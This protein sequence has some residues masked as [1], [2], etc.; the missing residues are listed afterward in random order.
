MTDKTLGLDN[1][2]AMKTPEDSRRLYDQWA[3]TYDSGFAAT[4]EYYLPYLTAE[5]FHAA[6][7]RGPVLDVGAG[8]GLSGT[9]LAELG[10]G[11]LDGLDISTKML[12]VAQKKRLYSRLFLGDV[13]GRLDVVDGAYQGIISS[14]TFTL[15]HVGP[16]AITELLRVAAS[17]ALFVLSVNVRHYCAAGFEQ[18][19]GGI[20]R[21]I[22]TP[23]LP[24]VAIYGGAADPAHRGDRAYLATFRKL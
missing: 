18:F 23:A 22:T 15:G 6:G 24:E 13:T 9:R 19:L 4:Q 16:G 2:Y 17:G 11:P 14:G 21:Q 7:G 12:A 5:A 3:T 1:A 20:S 10:V 8:T